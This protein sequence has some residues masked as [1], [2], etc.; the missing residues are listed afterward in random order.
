[1][2]NCHVE[3][4]IITFKWKKFHFKQFCNLH[5]SFFSHFLF[6]GRMKNVR[7]REASR[8]TIIQE[9]SCNVYKSALYKVSALIERCIFMKIFVVPH[10]I[11]IEHN[12]SHHLSAFV[13]FHL[14]LRNFQ[15]RSS[16]G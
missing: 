12:P 4:F 3:H 14:I 15:Y 7:C 5:H 10:N 13:K 6:V 11:C 2:V 9:I 8:R 16:C 1:M